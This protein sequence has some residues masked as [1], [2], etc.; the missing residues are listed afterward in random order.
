MENI[1]GPWRGYPVR[2]ILFRI[3]SVCHCYV[4]RTD[5]SSAYPSCIMHP[6]I[7]QPFGAGDG[8]GARGRRRRRG[9]EEEEGKGR[10][11]KGKGVRKG[12]KN[13]RFANS[14]CLFCNILA[15]TARPPLRYRTRAGRVYICLTH[16]PGPHLCAWHYVHVRSGKPFPPRSFSDYEIISRPLRIGAAR[17]GRVP[18]LLGECI[19]LIA[20]ALGGSITPFVWNNSNYTECPRSCRKSRFK[21][22]TIQ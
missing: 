2:K 9:G 19:L 1:R 15:C 21:R 4:W 12:A 7:M 6:V 18:A 11:G 17:L 8:K 20:S 13:A 14:F 16:N 5:S 22:I 3:A 10:G